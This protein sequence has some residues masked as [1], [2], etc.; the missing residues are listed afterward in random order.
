MHQR[1]FD[2]LLQ[3]VERTRA[4]QACPTNVEDYLAMRLG[5]IGADPAIAVIEYVTGVDLPPS[6]FA[7][8]CVQDLMRISAELVIL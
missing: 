5:T 7:H 2:G 8:P 4:G 6:V 3:Q 1:Y